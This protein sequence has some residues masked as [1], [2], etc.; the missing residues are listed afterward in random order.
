MREL[1]RPLELPLLEQPNEARIVNMFSFPQT[2]KNLK[3]L[4]EF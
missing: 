3:A 4:I 1:N 2:I